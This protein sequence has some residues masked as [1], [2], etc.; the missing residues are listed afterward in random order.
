MAKK[1]NQLTYYGLHAT[2]TSSHE[3]RRGTV[4][5]ITFNHDY[6]DNDDINEIY[7]VMEKSAGDEWVNLSLDQD[8]AQFDLS[9]DGELT[10]ILLEADTAGVDLA[11][12][13]AA[14]KTV[15][16]LSSTDKQFRKYVEDITKKLSV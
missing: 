12:Y 5:T 1:S 16:N 10:I 8:A 14:C 7:F 11:V 9:T 2:R 13:Q 15:D 3:M 4:K 6:S